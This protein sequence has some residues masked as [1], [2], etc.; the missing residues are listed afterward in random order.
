MEQSFFAS[1]GPAGSSFLLRR[2][3]AKEVLIV[4]RNNHSPSVFS[5]RMAFHPLGLITVSA[6]TKPHF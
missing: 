1:G 2:K 5:I 4:I 6:S 3:E